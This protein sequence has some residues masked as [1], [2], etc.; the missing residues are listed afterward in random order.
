[1][2][3][4]TNT[5]FPA[6]GDTGNGGI[7]Q[8]V[9]TVKTDTFVV[10]GSGG[11]YNTVTGLTVTITPTDSSNNILV[12]PSVN[13]AANSGHRHGFKLM[14]GGTQIFIGNANSSNQRVTVFQGNPPTSA[15]SYHYSPLCLDDP[16][17]SSAVTY[18]IQIIGESNSSDIFINRPQ[19]SNTGGDF[20]RGVSTITAMEVSS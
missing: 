17:T 19:S 9:Q 11:S 1:M 14:R 12:I 20:F 10:S 15:N 18:S 8:I 13:M 4:F 7:I 6:S 16:N 5:I 2:G 3:L